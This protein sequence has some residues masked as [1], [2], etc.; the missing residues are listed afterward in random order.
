M[1]QKYLDDVYGVS[2]DR[3]IK[4]FYDDWAETYDAEISENG[5]ATPGRSGDIL[6][7]ADTPLDTPI[8]D[9][10]CGTGLSGLA[11][12]TRGYT[13]LHGTD[14]SPDMLALAEAKQIYGKLWET[15]PEA[16]LPIV[17]GDYGVIAAV[18]VVSPGAAPPE[19][20]QTLSDLLVPG[21]RLL[22]SFNDHALDDGTYME[23]ME[24]CRAGGRMTT[25]A[26]DYGPHLPE[27]NL[28][29]TI[30]LFEKV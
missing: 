18:G 5:Y 8:L 24:T 7:A 17:P 16:P 30:Y 22:F 21:G 1:T 20:L 6:R 10:G 27:R 19:M 28:K 2:G 4:K 13:D 15:D 9:F 11:F 12:A 14:L 23:A 3:D 29:S 25:L 26:E